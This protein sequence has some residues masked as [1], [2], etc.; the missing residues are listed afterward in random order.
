M[1]DKETYGIFTNSFG[2]VWAKLSIGS[3]MSSLLMETNF[4][5]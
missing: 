5:Q 3:Q 2:L 4:S 1:D